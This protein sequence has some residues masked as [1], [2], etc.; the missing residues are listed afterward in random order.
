MAVRERDAESG[1]VREAE[2][3]LR[4]IR[5]LM[6]RSTQHSTF[7]GVSGVVAG[8]LSIAGCLAQWLWLGAPATSRGPEFLGLWGGVTALAIAA[9]F[10]LTKRRAAQVGKRVLS[11]LG[12][13]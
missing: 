1:L 13:Q 2:D 7:S 5:E 8:L 3:N 4:R 6:E 12:R 9:D 11:R 10:V